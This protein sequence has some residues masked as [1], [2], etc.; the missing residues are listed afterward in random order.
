MSDN[1]YELFQS[2]FPAD[3]KNCFIET[4]D[5]TKY[6]YA[7]LEDISGRFARLLQDRGVRKG[8]RVAVQ[9]EKSPEAVFFYL[10]CLRAGAAYLPLNTAYTKSEIAYFLGDAEPALALCRPESEAEFT[11]AAENAGVGTVL[12]LGADGKG[13]LT[14]A[15]SGLT[16]LKGCVSA[17]AGDLAAILYTSGTTGRSKGAMLSHRNLGSNAL[18]LHQTWGFRPGDVLLHAL[19]IFHTHG[20]F[21]ATNCL[22]L[23]G[24]SMLFL[25]KFDADKVV[26]LL[27]R[28][29][30][31]MGVPTF[32]V[33][34]LA[35]PDF[36]P[37]ACRNMR[38]FISGSAPLLEETFQQ[39]KERTGHSILERY[40]MT[41]TGMNTSNPLEGER[42]AGTVGFPLPGVEVQV[43]GED[44]GLLPSESVGVL[45]VR[46]PNVFSGYWRMPEKTAEEF[47]PD[48]FFITGDVGKIDAR[49][50][51]H[52]VGRA[53]DLIISGGYNVY[54][55]EVELVID[56]LPG[57]GESAVIGLAHPDFGEAVAAAVT[58][59]G[60]AEVDEKAVIDACRQQLAN[61]KTPKR[62]FV[63]DSLPR[64]S[65]GKVQKNLLRDAYKDSFTA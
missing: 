31:M 4:A 20:L 12:T 8:D 55:K 29:T 16:P 37:D 19:P 43:R 40:G 22:L 65:M 39:F 1:L 61:Y 15:A 10:A 52:I 27:P 54:P 21:V 42:R 2:R 57:V 26:E 60:S 56:A 63:V 3:R 53:K 51:V 24:S 33:R 34:L 44:G 32:Y 28:A 64:N 45:E 58:L 46:G 49:G 11:E 6:S 23:N 9:T 13:S 38:L 50:Y 36:G 59:D 5:G 17:D 47:Q 25:N 14:E 62:V 30:V 7:D 48:G 35:H 18:A 41:E